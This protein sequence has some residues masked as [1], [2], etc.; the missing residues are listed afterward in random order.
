MTQRGR[1][2]RDTSAGS[3]LL[4]M[5]GKQ[6]SFTLE[7][8]WRSDVPPKV[9]MVVIVDLAS[10]GTVRAVSA[11]P[12]SQLAKEQAE[13]ALVAAR[14]RGSALA[15][16][17]VARFG[18]PSLV[19]LGALI[20]G[21]FF[22]AAVSIKTPLG[23]TSFTFWQVLG[24]LHSAGNG[25][26]ALAQ[27]FS[28]GGG[29]GSTGIYGLVAIVAIVAPFVH[30]FWKDRRAVLGGVLP[31]LFMLLVLLL[32][33]HSLNS[34]FDSASGAASGPFADFAKQARE[35]A[36]KAVSIGLGVYVSLLASLYFAG[37]AI[38]RFLVSRAS[39]PDAA[40]RPWAVE[41]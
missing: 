32:I 16:S 2:L 40:A 28:G 1:V 23:G 11:V 26:E 4:A 10:D 7:G 15:S 41:T 31:L 35:E 3:G 22:L 18:L 37:S 5:D 25:L 39:E 36:M 27:N 38:R 20:V 29:G 30:H 14:E 8:A 12:E 33:R 6:Y 19:A 34:G 17:M 21:W 9:G 13:L 24:F